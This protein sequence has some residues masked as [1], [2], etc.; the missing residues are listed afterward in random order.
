MR[1][2]FSIDEPLQPPRCM[3]HSNNI[4]FPLHPAGNYVLDAA[5]Q[6]PALQ[7]VTLV[8][9]PNIQGAPLCTAQQFRLCNATAILPLHCDSNPSSALRQ[10]SYLCTATAILPWWA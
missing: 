4:G 7:D 8:Q 3:L 10:Q 5:P 6:T 9:V 2:Q 1:V